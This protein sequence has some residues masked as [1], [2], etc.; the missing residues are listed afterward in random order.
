M[1]S[2]KPILTLILTTL[3]C[4][5]STF[6]DSAP[7]TKAS[8]E[9]I[10]TTQQS[11]LEKELE[12]IIDIYTNQDR[13]TQ[14]RSV[15]TR[16]KFS[17]IT[18]VRLFDIAEKSL[19]ANYKFEETINDRQYSSWLILMLGFS[20]QEKYKISIE[21]VL[22]WTS[23]TVVKKH[24]KHS[25]K[26]LP[27]FRLWNTVISQNLHNITGVE[28]KKARA[29]N[30]LHAEDPELIRAGASILYHYYRFDKE[31]T[32]L[33]EKRLLAIYQKSSNGPYAEASAWLCKLL[34]GSMNRQYYTTLQIVLENTDSPA[35]TRGAEKALKTLINIG[36]KRFPR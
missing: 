18:D 31:L 12:Y 7:D 16:L 24:S 34:G 15:N 1:I 9:K 19:L 10:P 20:G 36:K 6:A 27:K 11:A 32:D 13:K 8:S 2:S 5:V 22:A 35:L 21:Q 25:L 17:G 14:I 4:S 33:A 26:V 28:L 30:M 29:K 23:S 3:L